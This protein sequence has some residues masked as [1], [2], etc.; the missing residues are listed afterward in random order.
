MIKTILFDVGGT[1]VDAPDLFKEISNNI[2]T[3][4]GITIEKELK[5]E[6]NNFYNSSKFYDVKTILDLIMKN[7]LKNKCIE[8]S[9]IIASHIYK[10]IFLNNSSL[11]D[12]TKEILDYLKNR[13]IGLIVVS[14]ADSDVLIPELKKLKIYDYFDNFI[15]SSDIKCYKT[16]REIIRHINP[17]LN[18]S[19]QEMLFVGD[20]NADVYAAKK[21]KIK[22]IFINRKG[23]DNKGDITI[24]SLLEIKKLI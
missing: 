14:D 21:L 18:G 9:Q 12:E 23:D 6:F 20:S 17:L 19:R 3:T 2:E 8:Q 24:R 1:L 16:S 10:D 13:N 15:I 22:S 4:F 11:F 5:N 7:I